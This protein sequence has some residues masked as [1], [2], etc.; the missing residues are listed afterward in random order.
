VESGSVLIGDK[1]RALVVEGD[2]LVLVE[3]PARVEMGR[4][5]AGFGGCVLAVLLAIAVGWIGVGEWMA[6]VREPS[7]RAWQVAIGASIAVA[8]LIASAV[9]GTRVVLRRKPVAITRKVLAV[10]DPRTGLMCWEATGQSFTL[11]RVAL[12]IRVMPNRV[13]DDTLWAARIT[14]A[15]ASLWIG[16]FTTTFPTLYATVPARGPLL[17]TAFDPLTTQLRAW[18]IDVLVEHP[19]Y[20]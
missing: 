12:R 8:M 2:A 15:V 9:V 17:P 20:L 13:F 14:F 1:S 10:L 7:A 18:G 16:P 11:D 4:R 6:V 5:I 3:N 19:A